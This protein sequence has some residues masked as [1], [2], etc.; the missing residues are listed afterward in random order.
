MKHPHAELMALYAKDALE[1]DT[2]YLYWQVQKKGK[3]KWYRLTQHPTWS[4]NDNYRTERIVWNGY[5]FIEPLTVEE[6]QSLE[7]GT[8][9]YMVDLT[10]D[11]YGCL[12]LCKVLTWS[13]TARDFELI[14][15]NIVHLTVLSATRH[16]RALLKENGKQLGLLNE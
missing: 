5:T 4:V 15:R 16:A 2:P 11:D 12:E 8:V 13:G 14:K 1:T 3:G 9:C 7:R 10:G 6:A